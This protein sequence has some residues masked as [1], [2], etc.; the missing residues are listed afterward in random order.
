[1][2]DALPNAYVTSGRIPWGAVPSPPGLEG[3]MRKEDSMH[4]EETKWRTA[5][6]LTGKTY[7]WHV[8]TRETRWDP[9]P[10]WGGGAAAPAAAG[11]DDDAVKA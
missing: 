8:D 5:L 10:G 6:A 4:R 3:R 2:L 11:D 7:W 1:M 9:P